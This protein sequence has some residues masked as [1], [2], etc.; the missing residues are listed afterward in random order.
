LDGQVQKKARVTTNDPETPQLSIAM[1]G[2]VWVP[3]HITPP[4]VRLQGVVG[5]DIEQVVHLQADADKK[6]PL[7]LKIASVSI[8]DDVAVELKEI[9]KGR[10]Y[11]LKVKN[12]AKNGKRY[13]GRV[14]LTTSYPEKLNTLVPIS[15]TIKPHVELRPKHLS[16]GRISKKRLQELENVNRPI[17][18]LVS[19]IL[20]KGK[21]L[22]VKKVELE[23]SL[24]EVTTRDIYEGQT[25]LVQVKPVVEKLKK[26]PNRDRLKIHTNQKDHE[27]LEVPLQIHFEVEEQASSQDRK[28]NN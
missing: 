15:G 21:D 27:V 8:P 19:V 1:K 16:F 2:K 9:E 14:K 11:E 18:G 20:N 28:P 6:E 24:F 25:V 7:K 23:N 3:I 26:G 13:K 4:V 10:S 22:K 12:K 17:R 5:D